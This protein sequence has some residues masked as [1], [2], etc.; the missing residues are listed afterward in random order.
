VDTVVADTNV[1]VSGIISSKG[2]PAK[3]LDLFLRGE[4][5]LCFNEGMLAEIERV[6]SYPK[7]KEKYGIE[8]NEIS[9]LLQIFIRYG[10]LVS[11]SP[12]SNVIEKDPTDNVILQCAVDAEADFIVT[13]DT[14]LLELKSYSGI[15]IISA[16]EYLKRRR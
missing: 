8:E 4:I 14:H 13:G 11:S 1:I 16:G 15:P 7:I 2:A 9:N 10:F 3:V 12:I 6:L 5:M